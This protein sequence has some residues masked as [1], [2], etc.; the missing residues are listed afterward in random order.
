MKRYG[1]AGIASGVAVVAL[2]ATGCAPTS[3]TASEEFVVDP[4]MMEDAAEGVVTWCAQKDS[5]GAFAATVDAFN[6]EFEADGY[7]LEL[8]EFPESTDEWRNQFVQRQ[9]AKSDECDIFSSDVVW[10]AEFANKGYLYDMTP[11]VED[12]SDEFIP[13]TFETTEYEGKNWAVPYGTNVGFIFS[14]TDRT[15]DAPQTWQGVYADAT[16]AGTLAYQG[17]AYEGLTVNFLEIASANG[18]TVLTE[19]GSE[20]AINSPE[21]LEALEFM[22]NGLAVGAASPA[23]LTY[24]EEDSRRAFESGNAGLLR[25]WTYAYVLGKQNP[26]IADVLQMTPLP[27]FSDAGQPGSGILGGTNMVISRYTDNPGAS[28]KAIDYITSVDGQVPAALIGGQP[29]TIYAAYDDAELQEA[30]PFY[31]TLVAGIEQAVSRPV[32]PVYALVSRAIYS[33]VNEALSGSVT[34]EEA[35]E[36]ADAEINEALNTF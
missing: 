22:V 27:P 19:D 24:L 8:L 36:N 34:P 28:L 13:S 14:R 4:S 10:T 32:T 2:I 6:A 26:A 3:P 21:N 23:V 15:A 18:G 1:K 25:N 29:A 7:T 31:E 12:R 20:S 35:L 5:S 16:T 33:N 17:S 30:L 9:E 11:Y